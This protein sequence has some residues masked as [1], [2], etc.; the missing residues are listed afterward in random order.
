MSIKDLNEYIDSVIANNP[1]LKKQADEKLSKKYRNTSPAEYNV[2]IIQE[3]NPR[4]SLLSQLRMSGLDGKI[5]EIAEYLIYEMDDNG[6]IKTE[7]EEAA[8]DLSATIEDVQGALEAIQGLE[9]AGIGARDVREC[10]QL[11]L[12]RA[13]KEGSLEGRIVADFINELARND[14]DVIAKALG[15][16]RGKIQ[17]AV[18]NIKKLNPRPASTILS[19]ETE[20]VIPELIA[21]VDKKTI[22]LE[23]NRERLPQLKL[24]NPYERDLD[25]IKDPEARK[26]MKENMNYAKSLM[27]NLK[28]REETLCSVASYILEFQRDA[29]AKYK[30]AIKSLTI[31]DVAAALNFHPSTISRAISNKYIQINDKVLPLKSLLSQGTKKENGDLISKASIK[32]KIE[33]MVKNED[34]SRPLSDDTIK[35]AL[36]EEE[37]ILLK[38]RTIAKYR[39]DL[40]I[41]PCHLRKK[42]A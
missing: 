14:I 32:D 13:G 5:L 33:I 41:L 27:D 15:L 9:P 39:K 30:N 19:K 28:R 42:L 36:E 40:R 23:L 20:P 25:I 10:L 34:T 29:L 4:S 1:F 38:R 22:R 26:F 2:R 35:T 31:K 8:S 12:K 11:Q 17:A 6:Y 21:N 7:I 24:Y 18:D 16:D 3:E 37:G